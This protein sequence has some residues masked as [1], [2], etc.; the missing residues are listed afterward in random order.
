MQ[1][2]PLTSSMDRPLARKRWTK[3]RILTYLA[4]SVASVVLLY[5]IWFKS[6]GSVVRV[7]RDSIVL[8]AVV[9]NEFQ[10][11]IP[12]TCT[13]SPLK[14]F[15]LTTS[16]GG[17]ISDV[18]LEEGAMVCSGD[19][20]LRLDNTDLRLDIMYREAQLF[21]QI[22]NLRNTRLAMEQR[23]LDLRAE[24]LD[25]EL[26]ILESRRSFEQAKELWQ[27]HLISRIEFERA[28]ELFDYWSEK[29]VLTLE[30]QAQDSVLRSAQIKQLEESVGRMQDNLEFV[31][32][33][34]DNLILKAP[35]TGQLTSLNAEVGLSIGQ[36]QRVGQVDVTDG[37]RL[38]AS[39]DEYYL[40]RIRRGLA[41]QSSVAGTICSLTVS[42]VYPEVSE[43]KFR[44]ELE[45]VGTSPVN[46][47]RGQSL[48]ARVLLGDLSQAVLLPRGGFYNST[49]GRWAFVMRPDHDEAIRRDITLGRQNAQ[50]FEVLQGLRPGDSVIT[51]SYDMFMEYSKVVIE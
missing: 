20:I 24:L 5:G 45:F 11:Y 36:G 32:T 23:S 33:R 27:Q 37:F 4:A 12:I 10:E 43:G 7:G 25:V 39:L 35:M 26:Q 17:M 29:R 51:S 28:K 46:L 47:R 9:Q 40:S 34:L 42:K 49:G 48:Q 31:K 19:S 6:F 22:N 8:S 13:V 38:D 15:Y 50:V 44:I 14:T 16:Q 1:N 21:E 41:A 18:Y 3:G 30:S 2:E